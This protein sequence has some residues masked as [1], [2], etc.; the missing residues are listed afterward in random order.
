[1]DQLAMWIGC[2]V[3]ASCGVAVAVACVSLALTY[4]WRGVLR[5]VPSI[6]YIQWAVSQYKVAYPPA[7]WALEQM[8]IQDWEPRRAKVD[9]PTK[10][11]P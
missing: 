4:L 1:M 8:G 11:T 6:L 3:M 5:K 9:Q 10:D 7:R 2:A